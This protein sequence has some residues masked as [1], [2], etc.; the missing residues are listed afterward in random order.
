METLG[1]PVKFSRT[2]GKV[3]RG[4]PVY[5]EHTREI[6]AEHGFGADEVAALLEEGAATAASAPA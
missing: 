5:G 3:R 1:L 6:L 4:A 2:P